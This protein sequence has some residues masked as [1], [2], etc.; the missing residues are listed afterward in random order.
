MIWVLFIVNYTM[1]VFE[2]LVFCFVCVLSPYGYIFH[3]FF[4]SEMGLFPWFG[5][6][7]DDYYVMSC[8]YV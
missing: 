3:F 7:F 1:W 4:F 5:L 2:D 6:S 8:D